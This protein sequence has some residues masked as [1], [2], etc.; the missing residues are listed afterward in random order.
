MLK[1]QAQKLL[2]TQDLREDLLVYKSETE[3]TE[4]KS[5]KRKAN[6]KIISIDVLLT[7]FI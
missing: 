3:I 1:K 2:Y 7:Q 6:N 5:F 4:K